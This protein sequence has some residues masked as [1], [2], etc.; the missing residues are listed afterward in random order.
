M[1]AFLKIVAEDLIQK[2]G[3][4]FK[5]F[6]IVFPN[7]RARVYFNFHLA[8]LINKPIFAP[9]YYTIK[10]LFSRISQLEI[11]DD[12]ILIFEL[13]ES[14]CK[15]KNSSESFDKFFKWGEVMLNDFDEIDKYLAS[16]KDIYSN[17]KDLKE[18][19]SRFDYLSEEQ[20]KLISA[21]WQHFGTNDYKDYKEQF[22]KTWEALPLIYDEYKKNIENKGIC[23]E[24]MMFRK[25][26][27]LIKAKTIDDI[28][29]TIYCFIGFNA[30]NPCEELLFHH[31]QARDKAM[32]YW[33]YD[34]HYIKNTSHAAGE[35]L[36]SNIL[37]YPQQLSSSLF[38][39]LKT[40]KSIREIAI[41]SETGQTQVVAQI[42]SEM[43]AD[44]LENTAIILSDEQLLLPLINDIPDN[45]K[46]VNI[47]MS[48]PISNSNIASLPESI[49]SLYKRAKTE[50]KEIAYFYQDILQIIGNQII[51]EI[52]PE[53]AKSIRNNIVNYNKFYIYQS[54]LSKNEL[55]TSIFSF[56]SSGVA[57][58]QQLK[59]ILHNIYQKRNQIN[60]EENNH[61]VIENEISFRITEELNKIELL[62]ATH[63]IELSIETINRLIRLFI[64][65]AGMNFEGEPL[66]GLQIMGVLETRLLDFKNII[67]VSVNEGNM[68]KNSQYISFI[69]YHLRKGFGLTTY[70]NQDIIYAYYFY[71]SIQR[72]EN[73]SFIYHNRDTGIKAG[74]ISRYLLQL[75][76]EEQFPIESMVYSSN[77][78]KDSI[79]TIS[80]KKSDEIYEKLLFYTKNKKLS[81]TA[82]DMYID[83]PLKF[84]FHHIAKIAEEDEVSD[85]IDSAGLGNIFHATMYS[86]YKNYIG[87]EIKKV[88]LQEIT[89]NKKLIEESILEAFNEYFLKKENGKA[90][91]LDIQGKNI[92]VYNVILKYINNLL[93]YD[94]GIAPFTMLYLENS[95][96]SKVE[97]NKKTMSISI[98]GIIDRVDE[99]DNYLRVID[100][101]TGGKNNIKTKMIA[102]LFDH[103]IER[104]NSPLLQTL[105]YS[106]IISK[107]NTKSIIPG[108]YYI[109]ELF[110]KDYDWKIKSDKE[111]VTFDAVK[112]EFEEGL[113]QIIEEIFNREF[114]FH[115]TEFDEKCSYCNFREI[116]ER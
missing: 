84:Y 111:N 81:P 15:I 45:I 7:K 85:E 67:M 93:E 26:A 55:F 113:Q 3:G 89:K 96:E 109:R 28:D 37:K 4:D 105:I 72:S 66:K 74:E 64:K 99:K 69:P 1:K 29:D 20:K 95:V 2:T 38:N 56:P 49:A 16:A 97:I 80:I 83:C 35:Y 24:G 108:L 103:S 48:Y 46:D 12:T 32:F 90:S 82:I 52:Y 92:I 79:Q 57:L 110:D 18:I 43:S 58:I 60:E 17:L 107:T 59:K 114:E 100:Y 101:K 106:S 44:E 115:Q 19:E 98:G 10:D 39:N 22:V 51:K 47:T 30:I 21:F 34:Q 70:E 68:P 86:L 116:C 104:R 31:Y 88:D 42:L 94:M 75:K 102:E 53:D 65:R 91:L 78:I 8:Q 87:K 6:R 71:R 62:Q 27:E 77:L 5:N 73:I 63:K 50:G 33:D 25:A 61:F 9:E 13:Y 112:N 41:S 11:A 36:R 14:Y 40:E 76:Y 54:S 23:Y